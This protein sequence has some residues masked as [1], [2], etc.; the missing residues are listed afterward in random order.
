[1][2]DLGENIARVSYP[3]VFCCGLD[4]SAV[5]KNPCSRR[6]LIFPSYVF[7]LPAL[8]R[9]FVSFP[10]Q[11]N[12]QQQQ[13]QQHPQQQQQH[14]DYDSSK[15]ACGSPDAASN[16]LPHNLAPSWCTKPRDTW[17]APAGF[18]AA[19]DVD[20][21]GPFRWFIDERS[22]SAPGG[23]CHTMPLAPDEID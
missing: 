1:M 18:D 17:I 21:A 8:R 4:D 14:V 10:V 22:V 12:E 15:D 3:L 19:V 7:P 13:Q 2:H 23:S 20:D 6:P 16:Q 5:A 11:H 9:S